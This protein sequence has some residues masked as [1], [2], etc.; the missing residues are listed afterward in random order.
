LSAAFVSI[1]GIAGA[2][3]HVATRSSSSTSQCGDGSALLWSR[4]VL[5]LAL[6]ALMMKKNF[7]LGR[8]LWQLLSLVTIE[9]HP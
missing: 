7:S 4:T 2:N 9:E 6:A 8:N 5:D 1:R 3:W